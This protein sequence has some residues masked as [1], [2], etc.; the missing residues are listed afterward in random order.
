MI[1]VAEK[2]PRF[3]RVRKS[4]K[5]DYISFF[6]IREK[7]YSRYMPFWRYILPLSLKSM[8]YVVFKKK[9]FFFSV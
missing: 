6:F 1:S 8:P 5:E 9:K 2:V 3:S 4:S 7:V